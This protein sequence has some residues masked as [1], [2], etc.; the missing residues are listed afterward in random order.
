MGE[1]IFLILLVCHAHTV[2]VC[3]RM[4]YGV[5]DMTCRLLYI[6]MYL[7]QLLTYVSITSG[8]IP[9][10]A[11]TIGPWCRKKFCIDNDIIIHYND[12]I[13]M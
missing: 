4:A 1:G 5:Y 13:T 7:P 8:S 11:S 2:H 12:I 9:Y 10:G 3:I 6:Y